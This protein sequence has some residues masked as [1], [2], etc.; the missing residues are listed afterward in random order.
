MSARRENGLSLSTF[1]FLKDIQRWKGRVCCDQCTPSWFQLFS[2]R[3]ESEKNECQWNP[4]QTIFLCFLLY[5]FQPLSLKPL[6]FSWDQSWQYI[7]KTIWGV[8]KAGGNSSCQ[9][10]LQMYTTTWIA[11]SASGH[12]AP[13]HKGSV[14]AETCGLSE[15][16]NRSW[17]SKV[18]NR[19]WG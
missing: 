7:C 14:R 9:R 3:G 18:W 11:W 16:T 17:L 10:T 12:P 2:V 6:I 5:L 8:L 13:R 19:L 1:P 15:I 4:P